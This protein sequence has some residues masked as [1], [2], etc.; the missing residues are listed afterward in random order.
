MLFQESSLTQRQIPDLTPECSYVAKQ[1]NNREQHGIVTFSVRRLSLVRIYHYTVAS[2]AAVTVR[3]GIERR[4]KA[5]PL[6]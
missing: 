5:E 3:R 2:K 6:S 4:T 1:N